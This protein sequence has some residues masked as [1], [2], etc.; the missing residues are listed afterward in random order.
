MSHMLSTLNASIHHELMTPLRVNVEMA[1][2]LLHCVE[3]PELI[4]MARIMHVN[5]K[6]VLLHANDLLD[7]RI[8][9]NGKFVPEMKT[10][11][12]LEAINEII[13]IMNW[14]IQHR[15]LTIKLVH[16]SEENVCLEFDKRRLQ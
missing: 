5:S 14:T 13:N 15:D 9:Q 8:I 3:D 7:H 11:N 6:L 16:F 10:H 12:V 4:E 1:S 2:Q